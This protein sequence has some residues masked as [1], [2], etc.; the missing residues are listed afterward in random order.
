MENSSSDNNGVATVTLN[1]KFLDCPLC[2]APL[3]PPIFQCPTGHV[4]CDTCHKKLNDQCPS[5]PLPLGYTRNR[6]LEHIAD[7]ATVPCPNAS[8]GC[9]Q[10]IPYSRPSSHSWNC[11]FSPHFCPLPHCDHKAPTS[12]IV[13]HLGNHHRVPVN[14]Y[15][16]K[17][18][19]QVRFSNMN[20]L[21]VLQLDD[22]ILCLL[23]NS[24]MPSG[25][26]ISIVCRQPLRRW[27]I[28]RKKFLYKIVAKNEGG[29]KLVIDN[30]E[31]K[32]CEEDSSDVFLYLPEKFYC[33]DAE[34]QIEVCIWKV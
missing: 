4:A 1:L 19:A 34:L 6:A 20:P 29:T 28:L 32:F 22:S 30:A 18:T 25:R 9:D 5:C 27:T 14:F 23:R 12:D 11:S 10:T 13:R 16:C 15:K 31:M 26:A 2:S 24:A 17:D 21:L 3:M 8:Y 33:N 7:S